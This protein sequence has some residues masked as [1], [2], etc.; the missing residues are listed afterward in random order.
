MGNLAALVE[1][2]GTRFSGFQVQSADKGPTVQ[3]ALEA[4]ITRVAGRPEQPIRIEAAGR[5]DAGVHASGQVINFRTDARH[6]PD[7]WQRALN[8]LL[9]DDVAVRAV[10]GVPEGF[11]SRYSA[12]SRSY[13]YGILIA[14]V[15]APLRERF[16]WRV[17]ATLDLA[18]MRDAA[19]RTLG[20]HDFGA[21]GSS[22]SGGHTV[23]TMLS[24]DVAVPGTGA[25][26]TGAPDEVV[27]RFEANAFLTGMVRRLVGTLVLVGQG[28]LSV[29]QF[30]D[31]LSAAEKGH[32]GVPAPACGLCLVRVRYPAPL[33][34]W[35]HGGS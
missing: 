17:P 12:L 16:R 31:I 9:P 24:A 10:A 23:R 18:A 32:A 27:C 25:P 4:A 5:T 6:S 11:R 13:E 30:G 34:A 26:G 22:P 1:Y 35:G 19:R 3:G 2:D 15:R 20:E 8:A 21:F 7:V 14:A 29:A 28:R 33:L